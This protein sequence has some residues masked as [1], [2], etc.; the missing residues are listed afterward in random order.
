[1]GHA[2]TFGTPTQTPGLMKSTLRNVLALSMLA[3]AASSSAQRYLTG[4][5]SDANVTITNDV[6]Y[7][8]NIDF[9]TSNFASPDVPANVTELE[10]AVR[11]G[12]PIRGA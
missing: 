5:F 8:T 7:G 2:P 12:K 9:L 4:V 3:I 1:M 11:L 6:I 10:T